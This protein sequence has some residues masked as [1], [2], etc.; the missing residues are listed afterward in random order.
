MAPHVRIRFSTVPKTEPPPP[1]T[2]PLVRVFSKHVARI[3]TVARDKGL[4][5]DEVLASVGPDLIS[6]GFT[7]ETG[8]SAGKKVLRPVFFGEDGVADLTYQIDGFHA[9]WRCGIEIEAGR[10][11]MGNAIY[12]D[13]IQAALMVDLDHLCLAVPIS[14][15][16]KS[17]SKTSTSHDYD[18]ARSIADALFG[19]SRLKM[20][21]RLLII[22]Y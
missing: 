2:E 19:H 15:K 9:G 13:L 4:T 7:V 12:R 17:G 6:L 22:G 11:T 18:N 14:Y 21:Y 10:A 5:S 20:P 16:F 3:S 8:K 1:F